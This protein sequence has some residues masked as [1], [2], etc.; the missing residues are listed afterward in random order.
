MAY[1]PTVSILI[2]AHNEEAYIGACLDSLCA[3]DYPNLEIIVCNNNSTDATCDIVK[4]YPKVT[5]VHETIVGPNAARQK[6]LSVSHGEII[7]TLDADCVIDKN[8]I[9]SAINHFQKKSVVAVSGNC[10]FTGNQWF[11]HLVNFETRYILR[12]FHFIVHTLFRKY[13]I[14][15]AGNAWYRRSSLEK[16]GG[17]DTS[18]EFWGDDAHTAELLTKLGTIV[19]DTHAIVFT[20][21]RRFE[22]VGG[23]KTM[24]QYLINYVSMWTRKKHVTKNSPTNN[25]R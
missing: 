21:P 11:V 17:F 15:L 2:P 22:Q 25:Y 14:M 16:I 1:T 3:S 12:F 18:I 10:V 24:Y 9:T 7:A 4:K 19:Y 23:L 6:A 5:L 13:G 20:S 8:W